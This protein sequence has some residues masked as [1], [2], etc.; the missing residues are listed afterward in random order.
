MK[1][2]NQRINKIGMF[3]LIPVICFLAFADS[4]LS[5]MAPKPKVSPTPVTT[6]DDYFGKV[7]AG[8]LDK[9]YKDLKD[10]ELDRK[11]AKNEFDKGDYSGAI[12]L[13]TKLIDSSFLDTEDM[14]QR[15]R[16]Y[17]KRGEYKKALSDIQM[18]MAN[19]DSGSARQLTLRG[20]IYRKTFEYPKAFADYERAIKK[21]PKFSPAYDS[22]GYL[23][24]LKEQYDEALKDCTKS[25]SL[26]K[27]NVS[28]FTHR[29][30]IYARK[31]K[32]AEARL[33]LRTALE[34]DPNC[35]IASY[36]LGVLLSDDE[37]DETRV[38]NDE[39][40]ENRNQHIYFV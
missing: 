22:R 27:K 20:D 37:D 34:L 16:A 1:M 30:Y 10:R 17:Y 35:S 11:T 32:I 40:Y 6:N 25:I 14:E 28:A 19:G 18:S 29:G 12:K 23:Y 24:A 36:N 13:L 2:K 3:L 15:S 8:D 5:Q 26:D 7:T 21:D 9:A 4:A 39:E 38:L 31:Y 33:D